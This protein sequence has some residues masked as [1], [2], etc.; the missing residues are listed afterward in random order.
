VRRLRLT[1]RQR[2]SVCDNLT[3]S[4]RPH[5]EPQFVPMFGWATGLRVIALLVVLLAAGLVPASAHNWSPDD[6][7]ATGVS[8]DGYFYAGGPPA[9]WYIQSGGWNNCHL[10]TFTSSQ[11]I[12]YAHWYLPIMSAYN[13]IYSLQCSG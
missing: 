9:Y 7:C 3:T 10:E 13:H 11:R 2:E 5:G 12:N 1:P 6:H 8:P 4:P